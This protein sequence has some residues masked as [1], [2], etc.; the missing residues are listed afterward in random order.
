MNQ[1]A[2]LP[3]SA[4]ALF[5]TRIGVCGM[6]WNERAICAVQL[7]EATGAETRERMLLG[8]HKRHALQPQLGP[9]AYG[10][11]TAVADLPAF[12]RQAMAGVQVLLAGSNAGL[13]KDWT[14]VSAA[15]AALGILGDMRHDYQ[16]SAADLAHDSK[17]LPALEW[18]ELDEFAVPEFHARVYAMTR[19]LKPGQTAT[20]GE[21][22]NAL[23]RP[24]AARAVG[25][26]LGANPF[27]P[28]VPC[29]RV[30]AA[31]GKTGGFSGG[32]GAV[33]KLQMLEIEGGAWGGTRSLFAD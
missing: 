3:F 25:Q 5:V 26:A 12:A 16:P 29:H 22:A 33:T 30:L 20:Y 24:G 31:G 10:A 32:Q 19:A 6:A 1:A 23:S 15:N 7:P 4:H 27:A 9:A 2:P 13:D 11:L 14:D 28:I 18:I 17:L 21:I 8:L